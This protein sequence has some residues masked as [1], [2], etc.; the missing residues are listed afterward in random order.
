MNPTTPRI[1]GPAENPK[2]NRPINAPSATAPIRIKR[3]SEGVMLRPARAR[4]SVSVGLPLTLRR[5]LRL[6]A[7][8][9]R[10]RSTSS[11]G[12]ARGSVEPSSGTLRSLRILSRLQKKTAIAAA[13][14]IAM[15]NVRTGGGRFMAGL[16]ERRVGLLHQLQGHALRVVDALTVWIFGL[17]SGA[18]V[19]IGLERV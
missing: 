5:W 14:G 2:R 7:A 15:T 13:I 3:Y 12:V 9:R 4:S 19:L 6:S 18:I 10:R 11:R 17:D 8:G 1:S 16:E